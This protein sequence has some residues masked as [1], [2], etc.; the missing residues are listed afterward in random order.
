[1]STIHYTTPRCSDTRTDPSWISQFHR[2][3]THAVG[4]VAST[5]WS[6]FAAMHDGSA[7]YRRFEHL[8]SWGVPHD[9]A[10]REAL[11]QMEPKRAAE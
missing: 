6:F 10:L 2:A 7:A 5:F 8:K 1:M 3:T 11:G 4:S 9:T